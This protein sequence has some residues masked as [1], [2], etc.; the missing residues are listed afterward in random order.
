MRDYRPA[1]DE[2]IVVGVLR[3]VL[4]VPGSRSLKDRR[5]VVL[6]LKD[7]LV[8]RHKASVAE[9]GHLEAHDRAVLDEVKARMEGML[10]PIYEEQL[11]G[12]AEVR[13]LFKIPRIGVIAGSMV[14][15]GKVTRNAIAKVLRDGKVLYEGK[16]TSLKRFKEDVKEVE[17]GFE[18]GI[19]V[20][21][22]TE[23]TE[24]DR[25]QIFSRVQVPRS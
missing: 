12:E 15:E 14:L 21:G 24:G 4:H 23:L 18:C 6:S 13:A 1:P 3:V 11:A 10:E 19:G 17:K 9:V 8:T 16:V 20:E 22:A 5:R 7:R 25:I 2:H